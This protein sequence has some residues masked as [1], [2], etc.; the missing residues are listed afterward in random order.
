LISDEI[1]KV[2][3]QTHTNL[4]GT[5]NI[6]HATLILRF[7][8]KRE[9]RLIIQKNSTQCLFFALC[10]YFLCV[11]LV[12][13]Y[14]PCTFAFVCCLLFVVCVCC[15]CSCSCSCS[16]LVFVFVCRFN[17]NILNIADSGKRRVIYPRRL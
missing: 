12:L 1:C 2:G 14:G 15:L 17:F 3:A 5:L 4:Q 11:C 9:T 16:C 8:F 7:A 6:L 13:A 10:L